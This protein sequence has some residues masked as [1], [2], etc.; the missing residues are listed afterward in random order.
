[1]IPV[2]Q[3]LLC[4]DHIKLSA[5]WRQQHFR[6]DKAL[7]KDVNS[8]A[9]RLPTPHRPFRRALVDFLISCMCLGIPYIFFQRAQHHRVDEESG[10]RSAAP[11]LVVGAC[12]CLIVSLFLPL[13]L[14]SYTKFLRGRLRLC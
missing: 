2:H 1:M 4:S 12:T 5:H 14:F 13:H 6:P 3:R 9:L 8:N 11:M 10:L 7:P